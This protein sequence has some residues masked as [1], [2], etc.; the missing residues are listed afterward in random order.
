MQARAFGG[1]GPSVAKM[2]TPDCLVNGEFLMNG[3]CG[4]SLLVRGY[5]SKQADQPWKGSR[6]GSPLYHGLCIGSCLSVPALTLQARL[7]ALGWEEAFSPPSCSWSRQWAD[8]LRKA[9][10]RC[11]ERKVKRCLLPKADISSMGPRLF[12]LP[13]SLPPFE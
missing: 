12:P 2:L 11:R 1:W 3:Y 7:K 5:I 13:L 10:R 4:V 8:W 6:V 9:G